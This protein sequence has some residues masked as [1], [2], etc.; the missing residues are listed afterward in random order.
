M[1]SGE[2]KI[3]MGCY[4]DLCAGGYY[5]DRFL[6]MVICA[7]AGQAYAEPGMEYSDNGSSALFGDE[8]CEC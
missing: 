6:A 7:R 2:A 8:G 1:E 5:I 4:G 3:Q